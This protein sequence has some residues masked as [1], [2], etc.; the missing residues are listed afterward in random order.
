MKAFRRAP[1]YLLD[2]RLMM[3][4]AKAYAEKGDV[5]RARYIAQRLKEFR[6]PDS[7][8]FFAECD[9]PLKAGEPKPFQCTPPTRSFT[10]EDFKMRSN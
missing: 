10:Y 7:A 2:T 8:E 3:A 6:N 9:K 1:H 4:W 5:E